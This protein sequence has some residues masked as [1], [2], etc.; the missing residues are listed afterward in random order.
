[1]KYPLI[2]ITSLVS[3]VNA[4]VKSIIKSTG[5][6][7]EDI[8]SWGVDAARQ[9][10]DSV[11]GLKETYI[12]VNKHS[13]GIPKDFYLI[14]EIRLCKPAS[15]QYTSKTLED[16]KEPIRWIKS[17]ILKPANTGTLRYCTKNCPSPSDTEVTQS[18]TIKVPPYVARF[19]FHTGKVYLAY[20][21]MHT[22]T[23]GT[24]MMQDEINGVLAVKAYIKMMLLEEKFM[25]GELNMNIFQTF[26]NIWNDYLVK[27]QQNLKFSSPADTSYLAL[28]Q[29]QVFRKFR[30]RDQ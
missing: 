15:L 6:S 14:D 1:M 18:F 27:A 2:P 13:A 30:Y 17:T 23:D 29:D 16:G 20:L 9:I 4:E 8:Y 12:T 21:A 24:V 7:D 3:D 10:V 22:D 28:Q 11:Y 19:S 26:Q 5:F 25:M